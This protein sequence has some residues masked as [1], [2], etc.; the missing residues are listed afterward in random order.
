VSLNATSSLP[1]SVE[2]A[3][4]NASADAGDFAATSGTITFAPGQASRTILI[5]TVNDATIE[6]NQT[7]TVA[8]SNPIGGVIADGTGVGTILDNDTKF[9]VVDDGSANRTFEYGSGTGT[10]GENYTLNSGNTAPRGAASTAAGDKVWIVD[11]NKNVYVYGPGGNLLGSW[12]AGGMTG[13]PQVEGIAT[14]G[15][16]IWIVD[17]KQ[18]KVYR[19]AGAA[20]RLSG[21]QNAGSNIALNK[22]N[23]KPKD[24][25]TDGT[26]L[27]IVDDSSTDKVFKY[28]LTGSLQGS[29]TIN[30]GG[31]SPTGI[32]LDP[33]SPAS[34]LWIVDSNTDRVYQF[35]RP[36]GSSGTVNASFSFVLSAGNTNPQGI[37]DPPVDD[38]AMPSG[39]EGFAIGQATLPWAASGDSPEA[40]YSDVCEESSEGNSSA[41]VD[42]IPPHSL[43]MLDLVPGPA[44]TFTDS[45]HPAAI[46]SRGAAVDILMAE[47]EADPAERINI[48]RRIQRLPPIFRG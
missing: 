43:R 35:A 30:G 41:S 33:A 1:V 29:W 16:D 44:L 42:E 32:T 22:S 28:N 11:A 47:W 46:R 40:D 5:Q 37:A 26:Y 8:L 23:S 27:W 20:G 10:P 48:E 12:S 6:L 15:T 21:S 25:V 3:T 24:I 4:A 39:L 36:T 9:Y 19:F 34:P 45:W 13:A 38:V 2:Y 17:A 18:S 31:G 14:N 7:F